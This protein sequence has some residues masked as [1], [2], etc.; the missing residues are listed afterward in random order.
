M[1]VEI[2][3]IAV[4][5]GRKMDSGMAGMTNGKQRLEMAAIRDRL[6]TTMDTCGSDENN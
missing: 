1:A 4:Y 2:A 6:G 3:T 5:L